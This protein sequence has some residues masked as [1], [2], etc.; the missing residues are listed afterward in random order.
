MP[1]VV[2][3]VTVQGNGADA[4]GNEGERNEAAAE[5][6]AMAGNG[7]EESEAVPNLATIPKAVLN[8]VTIPEAVSKL[9]SAPTLGKR[10]RTPTDS[11]AVA[12]NSP[13]PPI[14][15]LALGRGTR[16]RK[17]PEKF[18]PE[19]P[20]AAT[21]KKSRT[22]SK[23]TVQPASPVTIS[24][25]MGKFRKLPVSKSSGKIPAARSNSPDQESDPPSQNLF[26]NTDED[27]DNDDQ[28]PLP[29]PLQTL[30]EPVP[31]PPLEPLPEP[32]A[33]DFQPPEIEIDDFVEWRILDQEMRLV[34]ADFTRVEVIHEKH[35]LYLGELLERDDVTVICEGLVP[36]TTETAAKAVMDSLR[37]CFGEKYYHNFS[38][39]NQ[40][41]EEDGSVFFEELNAKV[42]MKVSDYCKYL[43]IIEGKGRWKSFTYVDADGETVVIQDATKVVFYMLDVDMAD[44]MHILDGV[45]KARFKMKET[46]PGGA[47]CMMHHVSC[48]V[49]IALL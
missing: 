22:T 8:L 28:E 5:V 49:S 14:T 36:D 48:F 34:L 11:Q 27:S 23:S 35:K 29:N 38:Q 21:P 10:K 6:Q 30:P 33:F 44:H 41:Q 32:S 39:F 1:N 13:A 17:P 9:S 43:D 20:A 18:T 25:K 2:A 16:S 31:V 7:V 42:S 24:K 46:L 37:F 47:W 15:G 26:E 4:T 3:P 40:R 45:F 19:T 12:S